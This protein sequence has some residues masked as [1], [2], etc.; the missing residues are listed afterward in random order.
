MNNE[1]A[2]QIAIDLPE[3]AKVLDVGAGDMPFPRAN[4]VL[5]AID[6]EARGRA[7]TLS[8]GMSERFTKDNWIK[9]DFCDRTPWPFPDK[10][11]DYAICS[12][13]LEDV[14][15]PIWICSELSRCAKAGYIET[16][17]RFLE[18]SVGVE[19]PRYAG[20]FHHRWLVSER[21]GRLEFRHKPHLL[22]SHRLAHITTV[23]AWQ[24]I[25]PHYAI[26][27]HWWS[28][29]LEAR[30]MLEFDEPSV[31]KELEQF[32]RAARHHPHAVVCRPLSFSNRL[33]RMCYYW[34]L[35]R[36]RR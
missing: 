35:A 23:R 4:Y 11:F 26:L 2:L 1:A 28:E 15:D 31:V 19:N 9:I 32:A 21:E 20:Y 36:G 17:S 3:G 34:R 7:G 13:V 29:K 6:Y 16:P 5:D 30:E 18:Q 10:F 33:K 22:H 25:S 14:R 12:H 24:E 27:Q 8:I